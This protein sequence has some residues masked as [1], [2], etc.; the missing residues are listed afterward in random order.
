MNFRGAWALI[1]ATWSSWLQHRGFFFTLDFAWMMPPLAYLF[2]W[3]TAAG[4][5]TIGGF[6]RSEFIG[7]YL[8]LVLVN[9]ITYSPG[10][11]HFQAGRPIEAKASSGEA[12]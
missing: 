7:Y 12:A 10:P 9:Q 6:A 11:Y 1:A 4:E 8:V 2:V 5:A 3:S